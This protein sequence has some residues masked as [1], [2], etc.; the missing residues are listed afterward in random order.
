MN[1]YATEGTYEY[2]TSNSMKVSLAEK[3]T[4]LAKIKD[5]EFALVVNTP[6]RGKISGRFGFLLRR[7]AMEFGVN[8]ITST[9]T[10]GAMMKVLGRDD[11]DMDV[12][13]LNDYIKEK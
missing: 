9:D 8:C 3:Q 2:F 5:R 11:I 13:P 7:A 6:T 1:V 4:V 12:I 10:L